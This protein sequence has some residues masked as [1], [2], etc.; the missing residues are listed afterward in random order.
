VSVYINN[1]GLFD[2]LVHCVPVQEGL[3]AG[4]NAFDR[5]TPYFE[6]HYTQRA[7]HDRASTKSTLEPGVAELAAKVAETEHAGAVEHAV[8]VLA[9][10]GLHDE[11]A[12][13]VARVGL[14]E[15]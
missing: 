15:D 4:R 7:A 2:L 10:R 8:G 5:E 12:F 1:H 14:V 3:T 9:I 6:W 13:G 11:R